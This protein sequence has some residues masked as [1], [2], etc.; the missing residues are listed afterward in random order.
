MFAI[1][2]F[3]CT[4]STLY[5]YY[6]YK[7][8]LGRYIRRKNSSSLQKSVC[9]ICLQNAKMEKWVAKL[10]LSNTLTYYT[11]YLCILIKYTHVL[12]LV[13]IYLVHSKYYV[14]VCL[15]KVTLDS[16]HP[17]GIITFKLTSCWLSTFFVMDFNNI[18]V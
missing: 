6:K 15:K 12:Y 16:F 3:E 2:R 8:T 7:T 11:W 4:S 9:K 17:T 13:F 10:E 18:T 5:Y 14:F 1:S